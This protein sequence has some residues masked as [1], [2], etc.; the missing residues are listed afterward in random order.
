MLHHGDHPSQKRT[1]LAD[2]PHQ[3]AGIDHW[4]NPRILREVHCLRNERVQLEIHQRCHSAV[5]QLVRERDPESWSD[6][7]VCTRIFRATSV[8]ASIVK[9]AGRFSSTASNTDHAHPSGERSSAGSRLTRMHP[10]RKTLS[11]WKPEPVACG[12]HDLGRFMK[13][14]MQPLLTLYRTGTGI[15][16]QERL[17]NSG[18]SKNRGGAPLDQSA[19]EHSDPTEL[20]RSTYAVQIRSKAGCRPPRPIPAWEYNRHSATLDCEL[21]SP[22]QMAGT[23]LLRHS[24]P[25]CITGFDRL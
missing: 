15:W 6:A 14:D 7:T 19:A 12:R 18:S 2:R 9:R 25:S 23:S 3:N 17:A 8:N 24:N 13:R 22:T 20:R 4:R 16:N 21:M 1:I 5:S 10:D 11:V